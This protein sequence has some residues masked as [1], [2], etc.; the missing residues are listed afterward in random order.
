MVCRVLN[1]EAAPTTSR[2]DKLIFIGFFFDFFI[3]FFLY[4]FYRKI[5]NDL[6]IWGAIISMSFIYLPSTQRFRRFL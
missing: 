4:F 6:W 5:D 2:G 1:I 3:L